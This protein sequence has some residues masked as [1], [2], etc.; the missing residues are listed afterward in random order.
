MMYHAFSWKCQTDSIIGTPGKLNLL[1]ILKW[2]NW[3][4][5]GEGAVYYVI[6]ILK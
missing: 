3:K 4:G 6:S 5:K 1:N 2:M